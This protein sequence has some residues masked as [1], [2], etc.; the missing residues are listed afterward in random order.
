MY[1]LD[2]CLL[3]LTLDDAVFADRLIGLKRK[4]KIGVVELAMILK[5]I[6]LVI[7]NL[8]FLWHY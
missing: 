4:K 6:V 5:E 7:G 1:L 3:V 2:S 8:G